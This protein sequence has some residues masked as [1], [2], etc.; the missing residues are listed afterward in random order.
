[1]KEHFS[2]RYH[3]GYV[4]LIF[5][6]SL[7]L[8]NC[9]KPPVEALGT[10]E[11]DRVNGRAPASEIITDIQVEEG[12]YVSSG[13]VL[14][15][16]DDRKITQQYQDVEARLNQALW[17]LSELESGPR[18][19][20]IAEAE[21]RLEAARATLENNSEILRRQE[22]LQKSDFAS[23]QQVDLARSNYLN[24]RERVN[25][26]SESLSELLAGTR[27]EQIEQARAQVES[28]GAQLDRLKLQREDYRI[29]A[30]RDG[31]VDSLP[32]KK[33][34][35]PPSQAVVSTLLSGAQPW[36]R[37]Y[38][39][40]QFRSRMEPGT[41]YQL[42]I[43]GQEQLF[44]ARLRS[45][46]ADPSFTPYFALSERDRSRLSYVAKLDLTDEKARNLTAGTPVQ[47]LLGDL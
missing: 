43:D 3:P 1:M 30:V 47:L 15:L 35:R 42:K 46:S 14:L 9:E 41:E 37:V 34:D 29:K 32:F 10:L 18:P 7:F 39:P 4:I 19:Q 25:E 20:N 16:I 2:C 36:A 13:T 12:E 11:W 24:A 22:F 26:L 8:S 17:R 5:L 31:R 40:E 33:G 27:I 28:L 21:A 45:V 23:Q 44:T 6:C 38:V